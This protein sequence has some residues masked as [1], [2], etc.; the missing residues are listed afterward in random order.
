[1]QYLS[2]VTKEEWKKNV[3]FDGKFPR[4]VFPKFV[5]GNNPFKLVG[6]S[7]LCFGPY[8]FGLD[9]IGLS[10]CIP[11]PADPEK[12]MVMR[13]GGKEVEQGYFDNSVDYS[14]YSFD[15]ITGSRRILIH[16]F[17]EKREGN[18]WSFSQSLCISNIRQAR[19]CVGICPVPER[20]TYPEHPVTF[21]KPR[22]K[23]IPGGEEYIFGKGSC[24]FPS[25]A[26]DDQG[27][28]WV[29]WEENGD[30]LLSSVDRKD[31]VQVA[32]EQDGSDS[33]NPL[34]AFSD[35]KLWIFYLNNRDGFYRLY[36]RFR[37]GA[38]F[39][40]PLLLSE[41]LPCDAVTPAVISSG[42][43]IT[44]VWS[45]WRANLRYP[46]F[47][48]IINGIADSIKPLKTLMSAS[49]PGYVNAWFFSLAKDTT[50]EVWGAWNQHYPATLGICAGNLQE[51]PISVTTIDE[52]PEESQNG[53]YPGA[54]TDRE[55]RRWVFWE[56]AAWETPE[57]ER[58]KILGSMYDR[59]SR[60][61]VS[62]VILPEDGKT[63]LNQ[64]PQATL[65]PDGRLG[66]VWSGRDRDH[67]WG[68]YLVFKD[69]TRWNGPIRLTSGKEPAHAPKIV[70]DGKNGAWVVFHEGK[71]E[72]M[73]CHVV[74]IY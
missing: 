63:V 25:I 38:S 8:R 19:D 59:A 33:Y 41:K 17:F 53:G 44:L 20:K 73:K 26:T 13:I 54:I 39:S 24:R 72:R 18:R 71:G 55:N 34:I 67:D 31:P 48:H 56:S 1:V 2:R 68:L 43:D 69:K 12:Y 46:F 3:L 16:G 52:N 7:V 70:P 74:R 51:E 57:G 40:E 65:F 61:W 9:T 60:S 22:W 4:T 28:A 35:G 42:A 15:K 32:V 62:P 50:E 11:N 66:V 37:D 36:G 14:I 21:A 10:A 6:D 58:Q 47:R 5:F 27:T 64:T 29:A 49:V 45:C 30:I 23:S